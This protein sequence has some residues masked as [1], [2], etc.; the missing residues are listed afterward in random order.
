MK[1][2][3]KLVFALLSIFL[4]ISIDQSTKHLAKKHLKTASQGS[5]KTIIKDVLRFVYVENKGAAY[6]TFK[7]NKFILRW[8][9]GISII[10]MF[11][12]LINLIIRGGKNYKIISLIL[13]VAG[14]IANLIDRF[15]QSYVVD[16]IDLTILKNTF[17]N[18]GIFNIADLFISL[19]AAFYL[20]MTLI[21]EYI[22]KKRKKKRAF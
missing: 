8:L 16:F 1:N 15:S 17:I 6:G 2:K 18:F 3:K 9:S 11:A 20:I 4:L 12:Y 19:G 22:E 13:I 10:V 21:Y 7:E 14:G 5:E